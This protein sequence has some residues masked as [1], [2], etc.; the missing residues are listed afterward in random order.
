MNSEKKALSLSELQK[1]VLKGIFTI[2][3]G[4]VASALTEFLEQEIFMEVPE[5]KLIHLNELSD[6]I[7]LSHDRLMA[8]CSMVND[9]NLSYTVLVFFEQEMVSEVLNL[10]SPSEDDIAELMEFSTVFM[11]LINE[12]GSIILIKLVEI[13]DS[14]LKVTPIIPGIPNL[15]IGTLDS[16]TSEEL[17]DFNESTRILFINSNLH[18]TKEKNALKAEILFIPHPDTFD[19]I[20]DS[21]FSSNHNK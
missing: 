3:A 13:I 8:I 6:E 11:D 14:F 17:G 1:D 18:S 10:K 20:I 7:D 19:D 15:R 9:E 4:H 2:G 12:M 5:I 16:L 21:L